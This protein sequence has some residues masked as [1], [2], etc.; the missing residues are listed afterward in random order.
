MFLDRNYMFFALQNYYDINTIFFVFIGL[1]RKVFAIPQLS[2]TFW[3]IVLQLAM[4][5]LW[6]CYWPCD[7][8]H[9]A[10]LDT[11]F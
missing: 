9:V 2:P 11:L 6:C 7:M 1:E 5:V 10:T 8:G 4:V 3:D